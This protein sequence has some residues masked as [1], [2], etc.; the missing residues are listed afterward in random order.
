MISLGRRGDL[1][2]IKAIEC[3]II[4]SRIR[5]QIQRLGS[6]NNFYYN[7]NNDLPTIQQELSKL[8]PSIAYSRS[9]SS[10]M[11][12]GFEEVP[13]KLAFEMWIS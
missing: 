4:E 7:S 9:G 2:T 12:F 8:F 6:K 11:R 13:D 3:K 10:Y 1:P 5:F